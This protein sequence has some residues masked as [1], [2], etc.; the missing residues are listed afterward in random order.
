[1]SWS[2][3]KVRGLSYILTMILLLLIDPMLTFLTAVPDAFPTQ[4]CLLLKGKHVSRN[5]HSFC[6]FI[7]FD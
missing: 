4:T 2:Y 1:M 5:T 6:R 3:Y 7:L